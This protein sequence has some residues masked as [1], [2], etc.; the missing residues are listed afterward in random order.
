MVICIISNFSCNLLIISYFAEYFF[1]IVT[2]F[3]NFA[4]DTAA[5]AI[6]WSESLDEVFVRNY[7]RDPALSWQYFGSTTGIM[8]HYPGKDF[9]THTSMHSRTRARTQELY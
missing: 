5:T 1:K 3:Y 8:R 7:N 4:E 2:V 9:F 6:Q